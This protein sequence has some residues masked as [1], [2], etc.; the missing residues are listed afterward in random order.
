M[1]VTQNEDIETLV[2]CTYFYNACITN[3]IVVN[4]GYNC[5]HP[6]QPESYTD[7]GVKVGC[8]Y[9]WSCPLK[10]TGG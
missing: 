10:N 4:S 3:G 2:K 1:I 7:H 5:N 8:C 9:G 6:G